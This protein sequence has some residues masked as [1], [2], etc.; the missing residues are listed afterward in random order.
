MHHQHWAEQKSFERTAKVDRCSG[1]QFIRDLCNISILRLLILKSSESNQSK[2][3]K[4]LKTFTNSEF[5]G[6]SFFQTF[7]PRCLALPRTPSC[8]WHLYWPSLTEA[9][10]AKNSI[11]RGGQHPHPL[12][13]SEDVFVLCF[14][15]KNEIMK[16]YYKCIEW[17]SD[18]C[19]QIY[20]LWKM[21][22]YIH[23]WIYTINNLKQHKCKKNYYAKIKLSFLPER[24][25]V[26]YC[27]IL[28]SQQENI[29]LFSSSVTFF[30][31]C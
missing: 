16:L 17:I 27:S 28:P 1:T 15:F 12:S 13:C 10:Q 21:H 24:K 29:H 3:K 26:A 18:P 8:P 14:H 6:Y 2:K 7:L 22:W 30:L 19:K 23:I 20:Y 11:H 31:I 9:G 4:T 5:S 25:H